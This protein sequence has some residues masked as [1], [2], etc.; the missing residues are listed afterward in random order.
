[1]NQPTKPDQVELTRQRMEHAAVLAR[2]A[3]LPRCL[4][5]TLSEALVLGLLRQEVKAF[6]TVLGHGST[7]LGEVLRIYQEVG[8]VKVYGVRSEIEASHA[9]TSLRWVTG[10]KAAVVTSIGPGALQALA[11]SLVPASDG[12]GVW[13][14]FGDET[15]EDEGFNMQQVP[16]H[17]QG[18]FLQLAATMSRAYTLHTP[19]ALSIAL[20]RGAAMVDHPY[21]AGPFYLLMPMNTQAAWLPDFNLNELPEVC[22]VSLGAAEGDYAQAAKWIRVAEHIIVKVGGGG[23]TAGPEL[24]SL[25]EQSGGVLVHTPRA[26][27]CIPYAHPQ[28][29]GV[30][31][32]KGSL[33][34]NY[35]MENADLLI[36][37][38]TRSVCQSD[39][40]RTGYPNVQRV[41]NINADLDDA[42]HYHRTLALVGDVRRT[43]EKLNQAFSPNGGDKAEWQAACAVRKTEWQ[44]LKAER[45]NHPILKD[46]Y[47]G[48]PVLTQPAA[49]KIATDWAKVQGAVCFFDAGDVQ[50]NG[51][52]IVEDERPGQTFTETG[53]SYMGFAVSAILATGVAS[54]PFCAL[55][56][57][58]DGSFTMNPQILIDGAQHAARGCILLL[59]N[60]RMGA[61]TG[62]QEAQYGAGFATWNT[63]QVDFLAWARAVPGLLALEGGHTP[64][65]LRT[66]LERAGKHQG[67]ALIHVPVY[68]GPDPLGGMGV[69][70]RWNVGNWCEDVQ[71][72]RHEIGL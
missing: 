32:S 13:Y 43:L 45:E 66:A 55:A 17:E 41:I 35:A 62:L 16:K 23:R 4:G 51:F 61:I 7:E 38:G 2:R 6:F 11:A 18:L 69:Y 64:E 30:G 21:R 24:A 5:L 20:Q 8:L 1:M 15:S 49:I 25:L 44:A 65:T 31:G 27:G 36:A 42:T 59:D 39:C 67:L 63:F 54:K 34:G 19:L 40:S 68:F 12:I 10:E 26:T 22:P 70:G 52:Q 57:T 56:L 14:L 60:G 3:S 37:V 47:W 71:K 29:M 50:A 58:G 28:N 46:D 53:A 48:E 72:L 33:P 9:A